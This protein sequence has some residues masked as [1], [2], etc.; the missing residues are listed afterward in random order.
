MNI[1]VTPAGGGLYHARL[2]GRHITK[3]YTP[4][5]S[6][7]RILLSEGVSADEPLTLT[8]EGSETICMR[9]TVGAAARL[10]VRDNSSGFGFRP[11][12]PGPSETA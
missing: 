3:S 7:A 5:F 8:H 2:H 11:Y 4:L 1:T 9:T 12:R 6:A 10:T